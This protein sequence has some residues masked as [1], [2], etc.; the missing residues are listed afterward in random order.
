MAHP[1]D[2]DGNVTWEVEEI[3]NQKCKK[4]VEMKWSSM[5]N[6]TER[7]TA[8]RKEKWMSHRFGTEWYFLKS[9]PLFERS[10][11]AHPKLLLSVS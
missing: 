3:N 5:Y 2:K 10:G 6:S 9:L 4:L 8:L 11:L 1:G 7:D